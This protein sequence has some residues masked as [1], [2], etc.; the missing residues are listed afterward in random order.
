MKIQGIQV[1]R[2]QV[3]V[4]VSAGTIIEHTIRLFDKFHGRPAS[5]CYIDTNGDWWVYE[6]T[7]PHNGDDEYRLLRPATEE[8]LRLERIR[9]ELWQLRN[10]NEDV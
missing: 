3:E 5:D 8:E 4:E 2:N 9:K 6:Y 1:I 10:F 7:H